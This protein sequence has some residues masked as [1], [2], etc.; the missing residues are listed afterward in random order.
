MGA[1]GLVYGEN[2]W[3]LGKDSNQ[4]ENWTVALGQP[5]TRLGDSLLKSSDLR[6]ITK[7][8]RRNL[9]GP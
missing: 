7:E 9:S 5:Q 2:S 8:S 1:P 4:K 3:G 6:A